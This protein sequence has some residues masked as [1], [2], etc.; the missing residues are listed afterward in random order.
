MNRLLATPVL[1]LSTFLSFCCYA[2][3]EAPLFAAPDAFR[4]ILTAPV[5]Q[6]YAQK[7][8]EKRLYLEGKWSY[9]NGADSVALPVKIRTRG[10]YRRKACSLPP[11]QL[12]FRKNESSDTLFA[13]QN[14]LKMVSPCKN[15]DKYQQLIYLEYLV[16]QF[17]ALVSDYHFKTRLVEVNYVD[18]DTGKTWSSTNFLLES[19]R[20]MAS[21]YGGEALEVESTL[22]VTMNLAETALLELFQF[23]IGNVDYSSLKAPEG[24]SCCHNTVP[25]E[26]PADQPGR[27]PVAYDFD[28]TG[29][30]NAPYVTLPQ[31][32]PITKLTQRYFRGWCKEEFQ[33]RDAIAR[34]NEVRDQAIAIFAESQLLSDKYRK[35][36]VRYLEKS[37]E[38]I[39]DEGYVKN[40]IIGRCRG[41][42]IKG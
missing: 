15:G 27:I 6:A 33:F 16:Y 9:R 37:Y 8:L 3:E 5:G 14:K 24:K 30:V 36:A 40:K 20:A 21:R 31:N 22:R 10:N 7:K 13:G 34:L 4:A 26:L 11:L 42:V 25:L 2:T 12:N 18:S 17:Y 39:N 23:V 38:M 41:E 35:Y 19:D 1:L 32:V 29:I 28:S